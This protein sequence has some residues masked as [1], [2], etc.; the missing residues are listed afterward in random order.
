MYLEVPVRER[1]RR[2]GPLKL[3]WSRKGV[4]CWAYSISETRAL[5]REIDMSIDA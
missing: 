1:G 2:D 4:Q 5:L 3:L